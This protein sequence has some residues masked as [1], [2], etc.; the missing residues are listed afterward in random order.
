MVPFLYWKIQVNG[1]FYFSFTENKIKLF[2]FKCDSQLMFLLLLATNQNE[3]A[4]SLEL[5]KYY[6]PPDPIFF[7]T[8][9]IYLFKEAKSCLSSEKSF[10][11]ITPGNV[12]LYSMIPPSR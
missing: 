8:L 2:N 10:C 9:R 7:S 11:S 5:N 3:N 12:C 4:L 1:I 6:F